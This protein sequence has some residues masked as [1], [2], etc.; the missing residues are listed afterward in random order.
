MSVGR[1][2]STVWLATLST[3]VGVA[4]GMFTLRDEVFDRGNSE[5]EASLPEY[6]HSVG[7]ICDA[8]NR[9]EQTRPR[10]VRRLRRDLR[11]ATTTLARRDAIM[12]SVRRALADSNRQ[13]AKFKALD[14]PR[15]VAELHDDTAAA[16]ERNVERLRRYE[17]RLDAAE[18]PRDLVGAIKGH[19]N[20]RRAMG[21]DGDTVDAG[22]EYLAG[23]RCLGEPAV[24]APVTL[25]ARA[26]EPGRQ[27]GGGDVSPGSA[28]DGPDVEPG[29]DTTPDAAPSPD[30]VPE[31]ESPNEDPELPGSAGG[32]E[33]DEAPGAGPGP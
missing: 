6:Q 5:A 26:G 21:R 31:P 27:V 3:V 18:D 13:L 10:N 19:S 7:P 17:S 4:T 33:R 30:A 23:G 11:R 32:D 22:L 14:V 24:T 1:K 9:T 28:H 12:I 20:A 15:K 25:P 29:P 8:L 16:W 2:R